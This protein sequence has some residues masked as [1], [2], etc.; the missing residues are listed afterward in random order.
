M[1]A[2]V[3][4]DA[5]LSKIAKQDHGGLTRAD[6]EDCFRNRCGR[7]CLDTRPQHA[8]PPHDTYWFVSSDKNGRRIKI[9]FLMIDGQI[10]LKSAFPAT[11]VVE[12]VF[13]KFGK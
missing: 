12:S 1:D 9:V 10:I 4:H 11:P 7:K 3:I 2:L 13:Q 8:T 5:I 6:I